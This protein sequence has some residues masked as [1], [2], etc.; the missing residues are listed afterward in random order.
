MFAHF[1][2]WAG[3]VLEALILARS[4]KD[5]LIKRYPFFYTYVAWVLVVSLLRFGCY[6]TQP[7]A[8][9][10]VY[11]YTELPSVLVGYGVILE[12]YKRC[13]ANHP[14]VARLARNALLFLLVA[15]LAKVAVGTLASPFGS[16]AYGTAR[17][18]RDLRYVEVTLWVAM[19]ALF[20]RYR[21]PA[22]RNLKGLIGGY[23]LF[24]AMSVVNLALIFQPESRLW[25]L[26]RQL[27]SLAYLLTLTI[28]CAALWSYKPEPAAPPED[29][30]ERD[31]QV[32]EARL[33]T[34][35]ARTITH[36][37]RSVHS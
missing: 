34:T 13:L 27:P 8:Y 2:W 6:E 1:I 12:I 29:Q 32:L 17:L 22:G 21:I 9:Q 18:G 16:L 24:I 36:L 30:I 4:V 19:L 37:V 3:I 14:G 33:R 11:W 35:L 7:S 10:A 28:W 25:P 23:G 20:S 5:G 26:A 15:T 31:Y